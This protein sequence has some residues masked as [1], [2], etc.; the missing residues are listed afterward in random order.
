MNKTT[1][2]ERPG[3]CTAEIFYEDLSVKKGDWCS[4]HFRCWSLKNMCCDGLSACI[5]SCNA[6]TNP[7]LSFKNKLI[8]SE[9]NMLLLNASSKFLF[10]YSRLILKGIPIFFMRWMTKISPSALYHAQSLFFMQAKRQ[11]RGILLLNF[12]C[13]ENKFQGA[14]KWTLL[15]LSFFSFKVNVLLGHFCCSVGGL[16]FKLLYKRQMCVLPLAKWGDMTAVCTTVEKEAIK[17]HKECVLKFDATWLLVRS[18]DSHWGKKGKPAAVLG[19]CCLWYHGQLPHFFS[20]GECLT[21]WVVFSVHRRAEQSKSKQSFFIPL[22]SCIQTRGLPHMLFFPLWAFCLYLPDPP[23]PSH[24]HT[25]HLSLW[26]KGHWSLSNSG[27]LFSLI[28]TKTRSGQVKPQI[29]VE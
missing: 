26:A 19:A 20:T 21:L 14:G 9:V 18:A 3:C 7:T 27:N 29:P 23:P 25:L 17:D 16:L 28:S 2:R 24:T 6:Q 15:C 11:K 4:N 1:E 8:I 13:D 22:H 10:N 5:N 12:V